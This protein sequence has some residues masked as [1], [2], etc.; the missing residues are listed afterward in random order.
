M[1]IA[2]LAPE[3]PWW[4]IR[5]GKY[6][7]AERSLARLSGNSAGDVKKTLAQMIHTNQVENEFD[8]GSTYWDC[9][10]GVDLRRTE[11]SCMMWAAGTFSGFAISSQGTYFLE[12]V[13]SEVG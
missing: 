6:E 8:T 3:S 7:Q 5:H 4:C 1:I 9:F 2:L 13:Q 10:K 12:Q 11:I